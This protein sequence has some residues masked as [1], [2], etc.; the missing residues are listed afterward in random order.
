MRRATEY[1]DK[2]NGFYWI[3]PAD[4]AGLLKARYPNRHV[5]KLHAKR[6]SRCMLRGTF[7]PNGQPIILH[8]GRVV[9]GQHRLEAI[10]EAGVEVAV[11]VVH[12]PDTMDAEEVF[13]T[14]DAV[15]ARTDADL[16]K[17]NGVPQYTCAAAIVRSVAGL[18]D[19]WRVAAGAAGPDWTREETWAYYMGDPAGFNTATAKAMRLSASL[20]IIRIPPALAGAVYYLGARASAEQADQWLHGLATGEGLAARGVISQTRNEFIRSLEAKR[21]VVRQDKLGLLVRSWQAYSQGLDF[22]AA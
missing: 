5:T 8:M 15:R 22:K 1:D 19:K 18:G 9:D 11:Y 4:A 13:K 20:S 17:I 6:L 3:T 2:R 14:I 10:L 16:F 21:G 12:L 7:L